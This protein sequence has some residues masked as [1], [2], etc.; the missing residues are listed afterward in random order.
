MEGRKVLAFWGAMHPWQEGVITAYDEST[1]DI[2]IAWDNE[3]EK[4]SANALDIKTSSPMSD[5][6]G[7]YFIES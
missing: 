7:L 6:I 1:H 5:G 3:L 2:L 4:Y